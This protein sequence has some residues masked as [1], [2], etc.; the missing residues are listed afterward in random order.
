MLPSN[1]QAARAARQKFLHDKIPDVVALSRRLQTALDISNPATDRP[2]AVLR[3][4]ARRLAAALRMCKSFPVDM[5]RKSENLEFLDLR[6]LAES[7]ATA[8]TA[9]ESRTESTGPHSQVEDTIAFDIQEV[10][11]ATIAKKDDRKDNTSSPTEK[12]VATDLME[13]SS[14]GTT[15]TSA[16]AA[17]TVSG[18]DEST[19]QTNEENPR[20]SKVWPEPDCLQMPGPFTTA[21]CHQEDCYVVPILTLTLRETTPL[22]GC[23]ATQRGQ[24]L[25]HFEVGLDDVEALCQGKFTVNDS[26]YWQEN[27][28]EQQQLGKPAKAK[29]DIQ[30]PSQGMEQHQIEKGCGQGSWV[31]FGVR[32]RQTGKKKRKEKAGKWACFGVPVESTWSLTCNTEAATYGGGCDSEGISVPQYVTKVKRIE[33]RLSVGGIACMDL[34]QNADAWRGGVWSQVKQAM[35]NNSLT[36]SYLR[37]PEETR[38]AQT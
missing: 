11:N 24:I 14:L 12:P 31:F 4:H 36:V 2:R 19:V 25:L 18:D 17:S 21:I 30:A 22:V 28:Y 27:R 7:D 9:I 10:G 13:N 20:P 15:P 1:P 3:V 32:F 26:S 34:W 29:A 37:R 35:A 8:G 33:S 23:S 6:I 38:M 5:N 16:V